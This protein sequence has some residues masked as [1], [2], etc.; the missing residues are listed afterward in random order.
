MAAQEL[1]A[2]S[3]LF[4]VYARKALLDGGA[5]A[6]ARST[7]PMIA[8]ARAID[9][10]A[11]AARKSWDD[12]EE[13]PMRLLGAKVAK[14][15]FAVNGTSVAPDATF[16]LRLSVGVVKGYDHVPWATTIGGLFT[17]ATGTEPLKLPKR[18]L[19]AKDKLDPKTPFNF[20]STDDII[21]GNSGS[22]VVDAQGAI[23]GLA[24]DGN[25]TSLANRYVYA[26]TTQRAVSVDTA[27][28]LEA[29]RKVYGEEAL[30]KELTSPA[31]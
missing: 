16:T 25:I 13:G 30:A 22:P 23:V 21:G 19:D 2:N 20:I 12:E 4:D 3:K 6:I 31:P 14:A 8:L 1:V 26:E 11:R 29:L 27:V 18:W 28:I 9:P 7:D 10:D 5:D 17:H 15:T 24:F